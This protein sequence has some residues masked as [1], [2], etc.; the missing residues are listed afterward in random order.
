LAIG[1]NMRA[2]DWLLEITYEN[3]IGYGKEHAIS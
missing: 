1:K 2:A 3:L